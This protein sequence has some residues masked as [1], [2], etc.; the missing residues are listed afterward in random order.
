MREIKFRC[1]VKFLIDKRIKTF[2][3]TLQDIGTHK[4]FNPLDIEVVSQDLYTGL[5]DKNGKEIYEGDIVKI[6]DL[7]GIVADFICEVCWSKKEL[8]WAF[9]EGLHW[10]RPTESLWAW[11]IGKE[12]EVIGNIY[13]K[14]ELLSKTQ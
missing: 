7:D 3:W 11:I 4:G 12:L 6:H 13:K 10:K 8:S 9:K 5:K 2:F 1:R 14:K